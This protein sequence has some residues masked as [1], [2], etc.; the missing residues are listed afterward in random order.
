MFIP[1]TILSQANHPILAK[2]PHPSPNH[3]ISAKA[4]NPSISSHP[5]RP[6]HPPSHPIIVGPT[7]TSQ[8]TPSQPN[9]SIPAKSSYLTRAGLSQSNNPIPDKPPH[10]SRTTASQPDHPNTAKSSHPMRITPS[11]SCHPDP[12]HPH[13]TAPEHD[14]DI[15]VRRRLRTAAGTGRPGGSASRRSLHVRGAGLTA[16][17]VVSGRNRRSDRRSGGTGVRTGVRDAAREEWLKRRRLVAGRAGRYRG[18]LWVSSGF[19][20]TL[21]TLPS[22]LF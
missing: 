22:C 21:M 17:V 13:T 9:H 15:S 7:Q 12:S 2:P 16:A 3:S 11:Q 4:P 1:Q 18:V 10:L 6:L 14:A 19:F 8:V 20:F 5:A